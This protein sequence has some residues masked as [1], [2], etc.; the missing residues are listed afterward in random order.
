MTKKNLDIIPYKHHL[1]EKARKPR[2]NS[3]PAEKRLWKYIRRKQVHKY[4][5]DR[6]KPIDRYIV[7]FYCKELGLAIEMGRKYHNSQYNYDRKRQKRIE[8]LG[9]HFL[10]FS[11]QNVLSNIDN[12]LR[13]VEQWVLKN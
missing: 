12:V 8:A 5:F 4:D 10:R 1:V 13:V 11:E 7:D 2:N 9:I 6:K 3:A